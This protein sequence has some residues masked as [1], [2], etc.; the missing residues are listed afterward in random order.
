MLLSD[1]FTACHIIYRPELE[2]EPGP[3][4]T[5]HKA[6]LQ[7]TGMLLARRLLEFITTTNLTAAFAGRNNE[8]KGKRERKGKIG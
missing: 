4:A 1:D 6:G 8:G 7:H 2:T 3:R 5:A